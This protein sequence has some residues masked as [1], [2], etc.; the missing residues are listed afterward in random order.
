MDPVSG[1]LMLA[2]VLGIIYLFYRLDVA[3]GNS[4]SAFRAMIE[5]RLRIIEDKTGIRALGDGFKD[6]PPWGEG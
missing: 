3:K 4:E 5:M 6:E 1:L 2:G